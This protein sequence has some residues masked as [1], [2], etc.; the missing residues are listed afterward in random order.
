MHIG[1]DLVVNF[2]KVL[3][4]NAAKQQTAK[5]WRMFNRQIQSTNRQPTR[6]REWSRVP[7][8]NFGKRFTNDHGF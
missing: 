7:D 8:L 2:A 5:T 6:R 1:H 3:R 4:N